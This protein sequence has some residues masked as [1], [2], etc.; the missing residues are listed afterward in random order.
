MSRRG[1]VWE[2]LSLYCDYEANLAGEMSCLALAAEVAQQA[3]GAE[4]PEHARLMAAS[5][6]AR[7]LAR[8]YHDKNQAILGQLARGGWLPPAPTPASKAPRSRPI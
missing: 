4:E 2:P 3:V 7:D 5:D 8:Q 1:W 6:G